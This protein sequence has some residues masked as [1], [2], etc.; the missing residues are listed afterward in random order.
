MQ[1]HARL[2]EPQLI[3]FFFYLGQCYMRRFKGITINRNV[4]QLQSLKFTVRCLAYER[5]G[6]SVVLPINNWRP[7]SQEL[8]GVT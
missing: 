3:I 5:T 7:H 8:L 6:K 1:I 2:I 4:L